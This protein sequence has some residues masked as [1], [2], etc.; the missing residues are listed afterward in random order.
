MVDAWNLKRL[1]AAHPTSFTLPDKAVDGLRAAARTLILNSPDLQKALSD[2]D[3]RVVDLTGYRC[4][5]C[6]CCGHHPHCPSIGAIAMTTKVIGVSW[7]DDRMGLLRVHRREAL[8]GPE[9]FS[10]QGT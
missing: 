6:I 10:E 8:A 2:E 9:P 5:R 7:I 3:A 4:D 1:V